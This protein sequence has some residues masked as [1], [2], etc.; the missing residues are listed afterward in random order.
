MAKQLSFSIGGKEFSA[1]PNKVDRK[2][3]YGWSEVFA[4][5]DDGNECVLV[6]AD[7]AGIIIPKGHSLIR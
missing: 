3:L 5:D 1:E 6:A 7:S 2:K 4:S